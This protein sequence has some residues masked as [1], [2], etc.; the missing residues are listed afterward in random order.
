MESPTPPLLGSNH[1]HL[2]KL[3]MKASIVS[4]C[5]ISS[6]LGK[7]LPVFKEL[8][9]AEDRAIP[10]R[11]KL[12]QL[13]LALSLCLLQRGSRKRVC[14]LPPQPSYLATKWLCQ[15]MLRQVRPFFCQPQMFSAREP[16]S[17]QSWDLRKETRVSCLFL[18]KS[19]LFSPLN[20]SQ[21]SRGTLLLSLL[22]LLL[23]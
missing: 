14:A 6:S 16:R 4:F 18:S 17:G 1:H 12:Q 8:T 2:D 21:H 9:R 20:S 13:Q 15:Q 5:H 23:Q 10:L 7:Y 3:L 19:C 11:G 22:I